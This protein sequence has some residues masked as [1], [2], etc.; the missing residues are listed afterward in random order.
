MSTNINEVFIKHLITQLDEAGI[1]DLTSDVI[2]YGTEQNRIKFKLYTQ[3]QWDD[4]LKV[5]NQ[6]TR[7]MSQLKVFNQ[8]DYVVTHK[9]V[10]YL[11]EIL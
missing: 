11:V 10:V 9:D 2:G 3:Q 6:A 4:K 8:P 1:K 5:K 7:L